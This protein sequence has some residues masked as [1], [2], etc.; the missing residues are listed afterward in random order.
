LDY[1]TLEDG[2]DILYQNVGKELPLSAAQY[3]HISRD[4]MAMQAMVWL[5]MVWLTAIEFGAL[6]FGTS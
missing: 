3:A 6:Q 5:C 1:L 2:T 4:N